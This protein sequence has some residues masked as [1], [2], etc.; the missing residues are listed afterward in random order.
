MRFPWRSIPAATAIALCLAAHIAWPAEAPLPIVD[1]HLHYSQS[2]WS[3]FSPAE[4]LHLMDQAGV[5]RAVASSTP[6]DGTVRLYDLAPSRIIPFLRPYRGS[7]GAGNWT[8]DPMLIAYLEERLGKRNYR[9]IGEFHLMDGGA[10]APHVRRVVE[11]AVRRGLYVQVHSGAEPV[12]G[13][14]ALDPQVQVLWAHAGMSEPPRVIEALLESQARLWCEV[15]FRAADI[16][17]EGKLEPSWR[18]LFIRFP[19]RFLIGTDTYVTSR[20]DEYP[21]LIQEHRRW[22]VQLPREVAE[23]IAIQNAARLFGEPR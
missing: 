14:F 16:A 3:R 17:P 5:A 10:Q 21:R 15:S 4:I 22:L 23:A 18:A 13:L 19:D 20:W 7:V 9:G 11:L 2:A 8:Q 1:A 6:D 12:R